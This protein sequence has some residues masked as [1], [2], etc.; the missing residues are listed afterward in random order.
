MPNAVFGHR[1][2]E[3]FD[4]VLGPAADG[5]GSHDLGDRHHQHLRT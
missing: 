4:L 2:C 5:L 1:P 3:G